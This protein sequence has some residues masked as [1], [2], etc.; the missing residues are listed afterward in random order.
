MKRAG[1]MAFRFTVGKDLTANQDFY[2]LNLPRPVDSGQPR[3]A[4]DEKGCPSGPEFPDAKEA[5][6]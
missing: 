4:R 2:K 1:N 3:E 5:R 6:S